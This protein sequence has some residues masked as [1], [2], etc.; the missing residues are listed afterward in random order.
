[1][2]RSVLIYFNLVQCG[3]ITDLLYKCCN[4]GAFWYWG[5]KM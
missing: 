1:M 3:V 4:Y 5:R 2:Y